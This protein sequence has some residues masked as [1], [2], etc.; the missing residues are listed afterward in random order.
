VGEETG[1]QQLRYLQDKLA[2][3]PHGPSAAMIEEELGSR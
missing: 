3:L 2:A 1:R